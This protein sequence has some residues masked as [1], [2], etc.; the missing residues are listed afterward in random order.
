MLEFPRSFSHELFAAV[1]GLAAATA[2]RPFPEPR[3]A[4][5]RLPSGSRIAAPGS[6]VRPARA[7][8]PGDVPPGVVAGSDGDRHNGARQRYSVLG[9]LDGRAPAECGGSFRF[10]EPLAPAWDFTGLVRARSRSERPA[11]G[12]AFDERYAQFLSAGPRPTASINCAL[13]AD[14]CVS[15]LAQRRSRYSG[16]SGRT[17]HRHAGSASVT[18]QS[19][20]PRS[21]LHASRPS[22]H[23]RSWRIAGRLTA[24]PERACCRRRG[25]RTETPCT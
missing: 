12:D 5:E 6:G 18:V 2:H 15:V 22:V 17:P 1:R 24:T 11:G 14:R 16:S 20:S 9:C 3:N 19:K 21:S 4:A 10:I 25:C 7:D 23:T 13:L 8:G